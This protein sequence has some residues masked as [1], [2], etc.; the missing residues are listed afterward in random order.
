LALR[1]CLVAICGLQRR[2]LPL[3]LVL[4][5]PRLVVAVSLLLVLLLVALW[6]LV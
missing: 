2:L 1:T 3:L 5:R 6:P 4:L